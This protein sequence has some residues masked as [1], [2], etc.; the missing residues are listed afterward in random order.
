[1]KSALSEKII[2]GDDGE[3]IEG[4]DSSAEDLNLLKRKESI[5][6]LSK[7]DLTNNWVDKE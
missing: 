6:Q 1:M 4:D 7:M 3:L 2:L 5:N